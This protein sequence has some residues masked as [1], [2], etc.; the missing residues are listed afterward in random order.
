M[1]RM[2]YKPVKIA[3]VMIDLGKDADKIARVALYDGAREM[4][5]ALIEAISALPEEVSAHPYIGLLPEDKEDLIEGIGVAQ[6]ESVGDSVNTHISMEGYARRTESRY[7]KGV[8]LP[9]LARSLESG[10]SIR[11][12]FPFVRPAVTASSKKCRAAIQK[13]MDEQIQIY[14][15]KSKT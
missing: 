7:P 4:V 6:F 5:N 9:M 11:A 14:I 3:D 8:P 15:N 1:A 12:K 2:T 10:S 13:K